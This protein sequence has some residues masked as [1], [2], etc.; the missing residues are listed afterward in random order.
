MARIR[1]S[2]TVFWD[3]LWSF[4]ILGTRPKEMSRNLTPTLAPRDLLR[5]LAR[6]LQNWSKRLQAMPLNFVT[7]RF[8]QVVQGE[9]LAHFCPTIRIPHRSKL[10][11]PGASRAKLC[12]FLTTIYRL[13]NRKL[14]LA[15]AHLR[16]R[17]PESRIRSLLRTY[18][19]SFAL[20]LGS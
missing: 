14:F 19:F 18:L 1:S 9:F 11:F 16:V 12:P 3:L 8:T 20:R 6:S 10:F 17:P 5:H 2:C 15:S 13:I 7:Q 4:R